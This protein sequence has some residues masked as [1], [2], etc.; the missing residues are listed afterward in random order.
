M[1]SVGEKLRQARIE[2]GFSL[3]QAVMSTRIRKHY[4]EAL[5]RGD[6][7]SLPSP[8][9][10]RG[11]LRLYAGYLGLP[12][13]DL[14]A[15]WEGREPST[16]PVSTA[17]PP[18]QPAQQD[19]P[20]PP[21]APPVE[22]DGDAESELENP[23]P[24]VE[25]KSDLP[26]GAGA[27]APISSASQAIL[28]EIGGILQR[29]RER[30][31]LSLDDVE[32]HTHI[33]GRYLSAIENGRLDQLPSTVQCRGMLSNYA[34]FLN[35]DTD[36][37]LLRFAEALQT[38]RVERLPPATVNGGSS[39]G[40]STKSARATTPARRFVTPDLIFGAAL[41]LVLFIFIVWTVSRLGLPAAAS[42]PTLPSVSDVLLATPSL[43]SPAQTPSPGLVIPPENLGTSEAVSALPQTT[44]EAA[45]PT[46][47]LGP[48]N[49]DPL[50]VY[51]VTKQRT[52]LRVTVD[53][54]LRFN[55]RLVPGNAYPFS[56]ANRIDILLGNAAAV[57]VYFNQQE[58]FGLGDPGQ[59]ANISFTREGVLTPTPLPSA[60]PS[61]TPEVTNT[62]TSGTPAAS[63][64]ITPLVP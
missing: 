5:E 16:S 55:G 13:E 41:I 58:L 22:V 12:G 40:K 45:Q 57:R 18:S 35:L 33:R 44:S 8:V 50:Q 11:F 63:P 43:T 27:P 46:A 10:G 36:A 24:A 6:R 23:V 7:E 1:Q 21:F 60:T 42:Q 34:A 64:T 52:F 61:A 15:E 59:S 47:T 30:L 39:G 25:E 53:G 49:N 62:P 48:I 9:Q 17:S 38:R 51:I 32:K 54:R 4:L 2:K 3:E 56:G 19:A 29:Q 26:V 14:V 20:A 28:I 37:V 31:G